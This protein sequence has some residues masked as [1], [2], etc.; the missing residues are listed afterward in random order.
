MTIKKE[1]IDLSGVG[2]LAPRNYGNRC[3]SVEHPEEIII[4]ND[5]QYAAGVVNPITRL[6][7]ISPANKTVSDVGSVVSEISATI[8]VPNQGI[9]FLGRYYS[10]SVNLWKANDGDLTLSAV[11]FTAYTTGIDLEYYTVNG[12]QRLFISVYGSTA[13]TGDIMTYDFSG[14]DQTWFSAT[15]TGGAKMGNNNI[16]MVVADNGFMYVLEGSTVHKVDGTETGGANGTVTMNVLTFP[17]IFQIL[18]GVDLAGLLWIAIYNSES[19]LYVNPL[20]AVLPSSKIGVYIWD[21][22]S[23]V[24]SMENFI[25]IKGVSQIRAIF[26]FRGLPA[27]FTVSNSGYTQ[28]R[29]YNGRNFEIVRE[30]ELGAVPNY[31]DSVS[32][33][34]IG[35]TWLGYNGKFYFYGKITVGATDALYNIG[36]VSSYVTANGSAGSILHSQNTSGTIPDGLNPHPEGYY[37][38]AYDGTTRVVKKW[39]PYAFY[40]DGGYMVSDSGNFHSMNKELPKLSEVKSIT[41]YSLPSGS[42]SFEALAYLKIYFNQSDT[43]WKTITLDSTDRDRGYKYIPV[44]EKNIN[45]VRIGWSYKDDITINSQISFRYAVIEYKVTNKKI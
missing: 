34:D 18:D 24:V 36:D 17:A 31:P 13:T 41:I 42:G 44:G 16:R 3:Y 10:S 40:A 35:I 20:S 45:S 8:N 32:V 30:L 14:Y 23:T 39:Y 1:I 28:L 27:C 38:G 29:I 33:N 5:N 21:R 43:E 25:P 6:G 7:Y 2:G 22:Q 11:S 12:V 26:A 9:Y 4:G 19:D 15:A 37:F